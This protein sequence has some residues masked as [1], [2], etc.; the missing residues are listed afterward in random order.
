MPIIQNQQKIF[1]TSQLSLSLL[2]TIA[3]LLFRN[4][5]CPSNEQP[6]SVSRKH[7]AESLTSWSQWLNTPLLRWGEA[8]SELA[9]KA[10]PFMHWSQRIGYSAD[11]I[12]C[13][14]RATQVEK[15]DHGSDLDLCYT[16]ENFRVISNATSYLN[17]ALCPLSTLVRVS[18]S[19]ISNLQLT[20]C[21]CTLLI[22]H[23]TPYY[24]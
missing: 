6:P 22:N 23:N 11:L 24:Y 14:N 3:F 10:F 18:E 16:A 21:V 12:T 7:R 13:P 15:D 4:L 19:V 20:R 2:L 8:H 17:L 9:N 5:P 1:Q